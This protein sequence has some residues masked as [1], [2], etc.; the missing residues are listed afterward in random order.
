MKLL[1]QAEDVVY[2]VAQIE[3]DVRGHLVIARAAG[4]QTLAGVADQRGQ[5]LLDIQMNVFKVERPDKAP[6][7]NLRC[8][9]T[10]AALYFGQILGRNDCLFRQH[11]CVGERAANILPPHALVEIDR[12]GVAFD[13]IGHRFGETAGPSVLRSL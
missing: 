9:Q 2:R 7:F 3:A 12:G 1:E 6:R 13:Q 5:A 8:Y 4:M 10:H 11:P